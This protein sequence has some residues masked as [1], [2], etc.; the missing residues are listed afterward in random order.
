LPL[1]V[2]TQKQIVRLGLLKDFGGGIDRQVHE[3]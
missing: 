1:R 3:S 2:E